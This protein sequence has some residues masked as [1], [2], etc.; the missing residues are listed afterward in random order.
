MA[1]RP[2][3]AYEFGAFRLDRGRRLLLRQDGTSVPLLPKAFDVLTYLVEREG[4]VL[5]KDELMRAVW[6][7][8][9]VEENNLSQIISTV[10]RALGEAR[11]EHR[12][13]AT[14]PGRGYQ[15]VADVRAAGAGTSHAT[16][17][18][19]SIVVLP[20][21]NV[22]DDADLEYFADGLADDL[23]ASLSRLD[24]LRVVARTSAFFFKNRPSDIRE[25]AKH[26]GVHLVLEG[27]VRRSGSRLRVTAQLINAADGCHVW[28]DRYEREMD[29]RDILRV[30]DEIREAVLGALTPSLSAVDQRPIV[31][32]TTANAVA[33]EMYLKGRFHLFRMTPSGID[34]GLQYF[35]AAIE[36]DP[37]YALAYVGLAHTQRVRAV[38]LEMSPAEVGPEGKVAALRALEIDPGLAEAHAVLAFHVYWFE[39]DWDTAE[40]HFARALK[41]NSNSADTYWMYA[42]LPSN[43]GRH[44][45]ALKAIAHA[46][47]LDPLSGFINAIEGQFLLHAGRTD[48]AIVRLREAI[49]LDPRS[50]VAHLVAARAY[51]GKGMFDAAV[52]EAGEAH[53]STPSNTQ[54]RA[55]EIVANA[56]RGDHREAKAGLKRLL[57]VSRERYVSSYNLAIACNGLDDTNEALAWLERGCESHDPRMVFLNVDPAWSKIRSDAR[58]RR[59]L[60]RM[61][62]D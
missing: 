40:E 26:L 56:G 5:D 43:A 46:R 18:A 19:R 31:K 60:R 47:A 62:F 10:R 36:H 6:P 35:K 61:R 54:A 49:E 52:L 25:I 21:A 39:W 42:H 8:T 55:L 41:L 3:L 30:Q 13:I 37:S 2:A 14:I 34:A 57:R 58:F 51:I 23:I 7:D 44:D 17:S 32:H 59:L 11:G 53:T 24:G 12:Y 50:R 16:P 9:F 27:S 33:H 15:F 20:F 45:A 48:D 29:M 38:S 22:G 1:D 28:S 4:L